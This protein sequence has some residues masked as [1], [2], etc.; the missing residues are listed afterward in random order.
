MTVP[1]CVTICGNI[2][3]GKT[4]K[5]DFTTLSVHNICV[6]SISKILSRT[7]GSYR[8]DPNCRILDKIYK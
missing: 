1:V 4:P 7:F 6:V 5:N 2:S 8:P 3:E